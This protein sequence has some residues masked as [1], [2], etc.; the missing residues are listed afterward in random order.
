MTKYRLSQTH[1]ST[2]K[3]NIFLQLTYFFRKRTNIVLIRIV[4]CGV[5]LRP[6]STSATNWP[7]VPPPSNY[8][9][10]FGGTMI[11][12]GNRSARRKPAPVP[13]CPP[14]IPN[15]QTG[16]EPGPPRLED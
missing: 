14:Q 12:M 6:P 16:R 13:L 11:G 9:G 15:D 8:D 10:G 4:S 3:L 5:Q 2:E 1:E 7:T